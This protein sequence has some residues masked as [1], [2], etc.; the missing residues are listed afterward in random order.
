[1]L[2]LA[3]VVTQAESV[4]VESSATELRVLAAMPEIAAMERELAGQS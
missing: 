3:A 1:M 2:G 4:L